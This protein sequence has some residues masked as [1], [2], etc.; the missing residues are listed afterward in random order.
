MQRLDAL[1]TDTFVSEF[2]SWRVRRPQAQKMTRAI[3]EDADPGTL[4]QLAADA[5]FSGN[6]ISDLRTLW[7]RVKR[8]KAEA[9]TLPRRE[10]ELLSAVRHL[11]EAQ[12][13]LETRGMSPDE[14]ETV[15]AEIADARG[16]LTLAEREVVGPRICAGVVAAAR[17]A[18]LIS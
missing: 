17:E 6:E 14:I 2:R 11:E 18:G 15:K 3:Q 7:A 5:G 10:K 13:K 4:L 12:H 16:A 8:D 9:E 1:V